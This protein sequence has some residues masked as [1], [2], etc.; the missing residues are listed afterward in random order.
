MGSG[1][2]IKNKTE[3]A[4]GDMKERVGEATNDESMANEGRSEQAESKLKQAG[5]HLSDGASKAK[6]AVK[7]AFN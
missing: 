4:K 5:E 2:K 1:D 3:E 7:D 6:D